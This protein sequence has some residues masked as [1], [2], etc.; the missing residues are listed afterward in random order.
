M[1]REQ[2]TLGSFN[3]LAPLRFKKG[4]SIKLVKRM[5]RRRSSFPEC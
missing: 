3:P 5:K 1:S 4:S 2:K